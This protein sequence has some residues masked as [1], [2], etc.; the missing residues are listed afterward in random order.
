MLMRKSR[1]KYQSS[2]SSDNQLLPNSQPSVEENN[3]TSASQTLISFIDSLK[4]H[5]TNAQYKQGYVSNVFKHIIDDE[6]LLLF[7]NGNLEFLT[8]SILMRIYYKFIELEKTDANYTLVNKLKYSM[9]NR[10]K[11]QLLW[12]RHNILFSTFT[13]QFKNSL[14][15]SSSLDKVIEDRKLTNSNLTLINNKLSSDEVNQNKPL[16]LD[17]PYQKSLDIDTRYAI[18]VLAQSNLNIRQFALELFSKKK[19]EV[20]ITNDITFIENNKNLF[21]FTMKIYT[22]QFLKDDYNSVLRASINHYNMIRLDEKSI[23]ACKSDL[24]GYHDTQIDLN[25]KFINLENKLDFTWYLVKLLLEGQEFKF[26]SQ[27]WI[28]F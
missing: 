16:V 11:I 8:K 20:F 23:I 10:D 15:S 2:T 1:R 28:D 17:Y 24:Y 19:L 14:D 12:K 6:H 13:L 25:I 26:K 9:S 22:H 3:I 27:L 5:L 7:L 18:S 4:T 21:L